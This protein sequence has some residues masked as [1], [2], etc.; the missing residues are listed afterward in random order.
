[1]KE[2]IL[3]G[4]VL[5]LLVL[6][7]FSI[8][9][10]AASV[11]IFNVTIKSVQPWDDIQTPDGLYESSGVYPWPVQYD[12]FAIKLINLNAYAGD[13]LS[14][15]IVLPNGTTFTL[16][17]SISSNITDTN[18]TLNHNVQPGDPSG[19]YEYSWYIDR[20][21]LNS[22]IAADYVNDTDYPIH[23]KK[24]ISMRG[25]LRSYL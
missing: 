3:I 23:V 6:P 20:C 13:T 19:A 12:N 1:M 18:V 8:S 4:L 17:Q 21:S 9:T 11:A 2:K 22:S 15:D 25:K 24:Q 7:L 10:N 14:C 5:I 16:S